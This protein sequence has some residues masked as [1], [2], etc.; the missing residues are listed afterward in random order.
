MVMLTQGV[1]NAGARAAKRD[2]RCPRSAMPARRYA[3]LLMD[4]E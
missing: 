2:G 3:A 1:S 4:D